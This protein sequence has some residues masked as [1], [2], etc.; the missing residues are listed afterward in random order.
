MAR[1]AN[2]VNDDSGVLPLP[3]RTAAKKDLPF[4][5]LNPN[6]ETVAAMTAARRGELTK[7]GEPEKLLSSLNAG[8]SADSDV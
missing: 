7:A 3:T 8:T 2:A 1:E 5:P 4:E 6:D